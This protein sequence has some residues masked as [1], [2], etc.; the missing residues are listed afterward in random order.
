[1]YSTRFHGRS[2]EGKID[3]IAAVERHSQERSVV[4]RR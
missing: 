4:A 2:R 1:M 3:R